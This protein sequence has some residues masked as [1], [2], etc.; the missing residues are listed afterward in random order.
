MASS[1]RSWS[2]LACVAA[3]GGCVV[4]TTD[5]R[6]VIYG[7]DGTSV[8]TLPCAAAVEAV[9]T[10]APS[11]STRALDPAHIRVMTWNIHKEDDA[12]WQDDLARFA[13]E[14]DVLLLQEVGLIDALTDIL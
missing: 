2:A 8:R 11:A 12:G 3:L 10:F 7:A 14:S 4:L 13:A 1:A 9:R 6:A 5:P